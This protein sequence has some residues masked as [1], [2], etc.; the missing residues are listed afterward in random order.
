M[1]RSACCWP[2][3]SRWRATWCVEYAGAHGELEVVEECASGDELAAALTRGRP[4]VCLLDIRM[5]GEDVFA[6]LGR[7][8][9]AQPLPSVIFATAFDGYA[10]RAF[11]MNAVDYLV[12]PYSED[13]FAEAIRR[14]RTRR[15]ADR[16]DDGLARVI[17]DLGP[18]PDRLLVPDGRRMVPLAV[19]DI[20]WIKAE[21]DYVARPRRRPQL[22][23]EPY[24]ERPRDA[25]GSGTVR[26]APPIGA[27]PGRAHP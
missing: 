10:V 19:S 3:T 5:P 16:P 11:D 27:R 22:S 20:V 14:V 13:R 21:D 1:T 24:P 23:G 17:R 12:K 18:R 25:P 7:A 8:S 15:Q 6:V 4:D 9:A 2:T 26:A